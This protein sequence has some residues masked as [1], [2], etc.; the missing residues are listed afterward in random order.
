MLQ[1]PFADPLCC[2]LIVVRRQRQ[3]NEVAAKRAAI[4]D[5]LGE[6]ETGLARLRERLQEKKVGFDGEELLRGEGVE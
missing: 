2:S 3:A 5:K 6:R 4:K 1:I